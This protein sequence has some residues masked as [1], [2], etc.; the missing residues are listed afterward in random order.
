MCDLSFVAFG[1]WVA[2]SQPALCN[3][4][5][6]TFRLC[7]SYAQL[8]GRAAK[9]YFAVFKFKNEC[10]TFLSAADTI[11]AFLENVLV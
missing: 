3:R 1:R 7:S 5:L 10:G 4:E 8:F 2:F 11:F 9:F 6:R